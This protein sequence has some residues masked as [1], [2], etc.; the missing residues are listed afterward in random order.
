MLSKEDILKIIKINLNN[1][2][3]SFEEELYFVKV[4]DEVCDFLFY[5]IKELNIRNRGDNN[6]EFNFEY[7]ARDVRRVITKYVE[8]IIAENI[9]EEKIIKNKNYKII[10]QNNELEI[11]E[12]EVS[13]VGRIS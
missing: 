11:L 3:S 10:I 9:L 8:N 4:E 6:H 5:K 1:V 13:K 12:I 7:N 2:L